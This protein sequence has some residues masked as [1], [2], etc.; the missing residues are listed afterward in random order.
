MSTTS[1]P[2]APEEI[3]ALT[4][5]ELTGAQ[6]QSVSAHAETCNECH[7]IADSFNTASRSVSAW[8][9]PS[10]KVSAGFETTLRSITSEISANLYRPKLPA[11]SAFL[12]RRWSVIS[13]ASAL[14][15][16]LIF[17]ST[18]PMYR[19]GKRSHA[20]D[21]ASTDNARDLAEEGRGFIGSDSVGK[22]QTETKPG[23]APMG[24]PVGGVSG[25]DKNGSSPMIARAISLAIVVK[26]FSL[27]RASLDQ[28]LARHHGYAATLSASTQQ[29][30]A[31]VL[32]ASLRVPASELNLVAGELKSLGPLE[33]ESQSG[34]EVTQQHAD[35][36]A[37]LKNSRETE[38]R[39]QDVL[40]TRTG[41][42]K[43]VLEVEQEIA[44]VRGEIEQMEAE[45]KA[46]EHRVQFA[47]IDLRLTEEYKAQLSS[48][49]PSTSTRFH[50]AFVTGYKDG[51]ETV[52]SILLFFAEYGPSMVVW[53]LLVFP[54]GWLF[55][56]RWRRNY[57][58]GSS[59]GA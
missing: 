29:N 36:I 47:S 44:R 51:V 25:A 35:L 2:V 53:L 5:G 15:L 16:L 48:P 27:A 50:N 31:R 26:D 56:R 38:Q 20:V 59:A 13:L 39:L 17:V 58:L 32:Q 55:W 24:G 37:R 54:F 40:R 11:T 6:M 4:D 42:V 52:V 22:L 1:H 49:S 19:M 57:A 45:Q 41:K 28:I 21:L 12:R 18:V 10:I 3:M 43:D 33:T 9:V 7:A 46:L 23:A 30:A 34:D 8:S 14:L